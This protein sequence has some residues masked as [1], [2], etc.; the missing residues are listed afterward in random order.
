VNCNETY[1]PN[2]L[3]GLELKLSA[4]HLLFWQVLPRQFREFDFELTFVF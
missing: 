3:S 1:F 4:V 2:M